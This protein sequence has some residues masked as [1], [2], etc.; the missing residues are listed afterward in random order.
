MCPPAMLAL[1]KIASLSDFKTLSLTERDPEDRY[2][3][4]TSLFGKYN[5]TFGVTVSWR[6]YETRLWAGHELINT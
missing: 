5:E 1:I 4:E 2:E 6:G 3:R